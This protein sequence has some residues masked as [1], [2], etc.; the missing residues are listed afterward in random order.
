MT[1]TGCGPS[2]PQSTTRPGIG[3]ASHAIMKRVATPPPA[4]TL[5]GVRVSLKMVS[6]VLLTAQNVLSVLFMRIARTNTGPPFIAGSVIIASELLKMLLCLLLLLKDMTAAEAVR[7]VHSEVIANFGGTLQMS[8]PA[9][10][11]TFQNFMV[12]I[13]IT[14]LDVTTYQATFQ[15]KLITTGLFSVLILGRR[16]TPTK[17]A[18]L[19]VLAA[20]LALVQM[21]FVS[22][23]SPASADDGNISGAD[24]AAVAA[25]DAA[26]LEKFNTW[27]VGVGAIVAACLSSG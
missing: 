23:S 3:A 9:L 21:S 20:G 12:F 10:C 16:L 19:G 27:I 26:A 14:R 13:A 15:L 4:V 25:A 8:V 17:W 18:S 11:Y 2:Q 1:G 24:A 7:T 22:K 6:L 5:L